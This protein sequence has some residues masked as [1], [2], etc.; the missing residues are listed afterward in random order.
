M[1]PIAMV[2]ASEDMSFIVAHVDSDGDAWTLGAAFRGCKHNPNHPT[3]GWCV[4]SAKQLGGQVTE[5]DE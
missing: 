2:F 1:H 3:W 4:A 5:V